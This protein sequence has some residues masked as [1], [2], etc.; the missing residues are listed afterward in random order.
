MLVGKV[1]SRKVCYGIVVQWKKIT[2][3]PAVGYCEHVMELIVWGYLWEDWISRKP[4][5]LILKR[6][7]DPQDVSVEVAPQI[8]NFI[9]TI[10]Q[11]AVNG[12]WPLSASIHRIFPVGM[13]SNSLPNLQ[14]LLNTSHN[15]YWEFLAY[16]FVY[17]QG[18]TVW[19]MQVTGGWWGS[20]KMAKVITTIKMLL[21]VGSSKRWLQKKK[22][23]MP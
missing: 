4:G 7:K 2:K 9:I 18:A 17:L 19:E 6:L 3:G 1:V 22:E 12:L 10:L 11:V 5:V 21:F 13:V 20:S 16:R 15:D 23:F 14:V 8:F